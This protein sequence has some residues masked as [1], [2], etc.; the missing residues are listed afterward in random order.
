LKRLIVVDLDGT[1]VH[2]DMLVEN[3]FLFLKK[4]PL[5]FLYVIYWLV[6]GKARL[7][8]ELASAVLPGVSDLPYNEELVGWLKLRRQQG[9]QLVLATASHKLIAEAVAKHLNLFDEVFGTDTINLSS[10]KK[11]SLLVEKFGNKK[12]DYVGNSRDDL[13]VWEAADRILVANPRGGLLASARKLG[14]VT[15]VF[16]EHKPSL[17]TAIRALR[18]H[19]WL[20]NLLIF[21]PLLASHRI[22]EPTLLVNGLLAFLAFGACASSVYLLNDLLDLPDDRQHATKKFRPLAAGTLDI[23]SALWLIPIL[24]CF[25]VVICVLFLPLSF[26]LALVVYYA[27]TL[28]YSMTLKRLVMVDVVCLALLYSIRV[29]AGAAAM[30]LAATFWIL[31]FCMFIF[32]SLAFVKRYTELMF[33]RNSG[34]T[35]KSA[36]RGYYPDDLELLASLGGSSGYISALVLA[37]YINDTSA[38]SLYGS[39]QWMWAACP[40]LLFWLS[41][42]WLLAHRGEMNDDPIIFAIRDPVSRWIG[43]AFLLVFALAAL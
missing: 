31:A 7:K 17:K 3:F 13:A 10:E 40:L 32:L 15:E 34:K 28:A 14:P 8:S 38:S 19:Q 4:Y 12:F 1:L 2:T 6:Q 9:D 18:L 29:I 16:D 35:G 21:V 26:G 41:R 23:F 37:L 25:A 20:K 30:G 43:A 24:L 42:V 11:R 27:L 33:A 5:R 22:T 36:G 39:P